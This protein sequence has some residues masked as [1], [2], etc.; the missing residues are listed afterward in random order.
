MD[1]LSVFLTTVSTI[2][3]ILLL[4]FNTNAFVAYCELLDFK[5][6]LLG[7]TSDSTDLTFPQHLFIK[8]K[9]L[10]K[11]QICIFLIKL[12]TCPI[13]LSTWLCLFG[14][15]FIGGIMS[16]PILYITVLFTYYTL[17]RCIG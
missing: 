8:S 1:Q 9:I 5:K 6:I 15:F 11:C 4:W 13:C 10:I 3:S 7:Y 14:C 2:T 16:F 17:I 12:I